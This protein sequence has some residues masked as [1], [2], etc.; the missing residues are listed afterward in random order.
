MNILYLDDYK[1]EE[2]ALLTD[3][4][5]TCKRISL[6]ETLTNGRIETIFP[7]GVFELRSRRMSEKEYNKIHDLLFQAGLSLLTSAEAFTIGED[8]SRQYPLLGEFSPCAMTADARETDANLFKAILDQGFRIPVFVRSEIE[9]AAKYVGVDGCIISIASEACVEHVVRNLRTH[10]PGF[11]TIILKEVA[12][13]C[14]DTN[15]GRPMEYRVISIGGEFL[16]FDSDKHISV[17]LPDPVNLGLRSFV[18]AALSRL[19]EGGANGSL[20][21]DVAMTTNGPIV[22]ECKNFNN[23]TI[24]A[25]SRFGGLLTNRKWEK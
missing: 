21:L 11:R 3:L 5:V 22:I 23:G 2:Q 4:G 16:M 18:D 10:V 12:D 14:L 15:S 6:S 9:S 13:I 24:K 7:G 20:F 1:P 17:E 25:I 19:A 8:F